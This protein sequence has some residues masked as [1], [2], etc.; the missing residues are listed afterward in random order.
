MAARM[1]AQ[2]MNIYLCRTRFPDLPNCFPSA[3]FKPSYLRLCAFSCNHATEAIQKSENAALLSNLSILGVDIKMAQKRQPGVFRKV[4]TNEEGVAD[5]LRSKGANCKTIASVISRYPRAITRSYHHLEERWQLWRSIFK[6]DSEIIC[7]IERSPESYFRSSDNGNFEKNISFL[8]SL[9]LTSKD[10]HRIL[11]TAPRAFSNSLELN[12]QMA[13]LL[14]D[15]GVSLG[16]EN[17]D[18]FVKRIIT[19]NAYIL[20]RSTK[21]I[22]TNVDFFREAL[23]PSNSELIKLLQGQGA[24]VLDL[25]T[26][27]MK[28]NFKNISEQLYSLGC[29]TEEVQKFFLDYP[30]AF[31]A[32]FEKLSNKI[33]CLL[34]SEINIKQLLNKPRI[35][36]FSAINLKNRIKELERVGYDFTKHGVT[37]LDSSR[38]RFEAKLGKLNKEE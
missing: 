8:Y 17:P 25:S 3:W 1:V 28:R 31:Y 33:D 7:I 19:K 30:P 11:T 37:I 6:T 24:E 15:L 26:D 13:K 4:V 32:S 36:E 38:R 29:S 5:F 10:L 9:G 2:A 35:L 27:Y 20:I 18:D 16:N 22:K 23:E 21:R 34:E 14:R 12:K